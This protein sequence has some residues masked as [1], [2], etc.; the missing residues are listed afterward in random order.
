M[1]K[2]AILGASGAIGSAFVNLLAQHNDTQIIYA[3]SRSA[4]AFEESKIKTITLDIESESSIQ[5]AVKEIEGKL[6]GVIIASGIL[7]TNTIKPE[8]ALKDICL[9]NFEKIFAVN[10]FGPALAMKYFIPLLNKEK[11][12]FFAI[13][14]AR[15]GSLTDNKL[16]GWYAYRASKAALNMLIKNASIE[17]KR[18]NK[19][20]TIIGLQPGTVDSP[21]SAPFQTR[22]PKDKLFTPEYSAS[23]LLNV[24]T[25]ADVN[26]SGECF[27]YNGVRIDY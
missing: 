16:G 14:S 1:K 21:L 10:T 27:D 12:S 9:S 17:L 25:N 8:K 20:A 18:T 7:H 22:V 15:V 3:C 6:D 24:I 4:K 13:I 11:P 19:N 26:D 5:A 23:K 2:F